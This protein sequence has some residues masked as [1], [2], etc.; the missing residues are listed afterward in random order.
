MDDPKPSSVT[1]DRNPRLSIQASGSSDAVLRH[2]SPWG[3]TI[4]IPLFIYG[5]IPVIAGGMGLLFVPAMLGGAVSIGQETTPLKFVGWVLF[6]LAVTAH[7]CAM[8]AA[9]RRFSRLLWRRGVFVAAVGTVV[10]GIVIAT[11]YICY[12]AF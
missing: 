12:V 5:A 11:F 7:G 1:A 8:I 4:A 9:G 10:P 6:H 3:V 2:R